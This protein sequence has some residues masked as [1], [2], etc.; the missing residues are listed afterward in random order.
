MKILHIII[1]LDV[2]GAELMLKRLIESHCG[3]SN[4]HHS[5][6]SLGDIG[7][8]GKQLL[9]LGIEVVSLHLNSIFQLPVV[10]F[11][12]CRLIRRQ[13]PDI[14]QTWMYHADLI[15]GIAAR[16]AGYRRVIWGIRNTDLYS[17]KGVSQTTGL[18]MKLCSV[19]SNFIPHTIL[20]V[21]Q[22]AKITHAEAGYALS[23][24][25]VISNG[26]DTE[27]YKPD[28]DARRRTRESLNLPSDA[29]I[30]GSIGR[31]NEYKDHRS[32]IIAAA[33]LAST[34][35]RTYFLMVG[36]G[37]DSNNTTIMRWIKETDY[38]DR[39]RLL[40]ERSDVPSILA[41]MDI[42]CLHSKSEGF[43]NVLGEAM[44]AGL[45]SVVTDVGDAGLLLGEGGLVV[46]PQD[47]EALA[48]SLL[49]LVQYSPDTRASFGIAARKR[50]KENYSI[51]VVKR[52]Y[53]ELYQKVMSV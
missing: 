42:F 5:V 50:I 37:V 40:G 29:L 51:D 22:R 20:C 3:N 46:S 9:E 8:V 52:K 13:R 25:T 48:Q 10:F 33:N 39:Y 14:L 43:P 34:D 24:M 11:R 32:F 28:L 12:L 4:Y 53:E 6:V 16:L 45:P 23:K 1:G 19:M 44:C 26:F 30:V 7:P 31:F 41:A 36:R 38:A 21:A 27:M 17:N 47:T 15:G 2:G 18:I 35:N 49:T